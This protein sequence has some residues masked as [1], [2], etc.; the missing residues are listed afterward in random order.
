MRRSWRRSTG[1]S[2]RRRRPRAEPR[3]WCRRTRPSRRSRCRRRPRRCR[4]RPLPRH[5]TPSGSRNRCRPARRA[6]GCRPSSRCRRRPRRSRTS[7]AGWSRAPATCPLR[8]SRTPRPPGTPRRSPS[9]RSRPPR[10]SPPPPGE[11]CSA[12]TSPTPCRGR[13]RS[14]APSCARRAEGSGR[15]SGPPCGSS[16]S[17][18]CRPGGRTWCGTRRGRPRLAERRTRR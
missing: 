6:S 4:G 10:R 7:R 15:R 16:R 3:R 2:A 9:R 11:A 5:R 1:P 13:A 17:R 8:R 12:G 18:S 14:P